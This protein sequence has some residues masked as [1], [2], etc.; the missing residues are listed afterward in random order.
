VDEND[1]PVPPNTVGEL[2]VRTA[3]PWTLNA[4]YLN[5]P[6]ATQA[7]WRNGWFHTGDAFTCDEDGN[8]YFRDRLKDCIRRKGENVSSFEVESIVKRHP[9]VLDC[10][11]V[12]TKLPNG[13]DAEIRLFVVPK[14]GRSID[15]AALIRW[16]IPIM[17]R[18]MVPRYV[19]FATSLPQTPTLK[20]QKALLRN[21]PMGPDIWDRER[22]GIVVPR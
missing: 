14:S 17:P 19:E 13:G 12:A 21:Q 20:V 9:D 11:A 3:E 7:A 1:Q 18:F 15:A 6:E 22:A 16:L 5:N 4:G 8:Y 10:A 2:I